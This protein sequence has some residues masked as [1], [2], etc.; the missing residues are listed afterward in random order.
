MESR[1]EKRTK[2]SQKAKRCLAELLTPITKTA[3]RLDKIFAAA[4]TSASTATTAC[5][6]TTTT[7]CGTNLIYNNS[8]NSFESPMP[9]MN[10]A[11]DFARNGDARGTKRCWEE[12]HTPVPRAA[13]AVATAPGAFYG[14]DYE[15]TTRVGALD[16]RIKNFRND[17]DID[18]FDDCFSIGMRMQRMMEGGE[19][20]IG[21]FT[22]IPSEVSAS[23]GGIPMIDSN[24][25]KQLLIEDANRVVLIDCRYFYEYQNGHI[26]QSAHVMFPED[27]QRGFLLARDKLRL[28]CTNN[29][30]NSNSSNNRDSERKENLVYVFYDDG[31]ANAMPMH[32][33]A[34]QLFR[35]IR[36][37]DRLDNMHTYPNLYFPNMYVLKGGF[38]AFIESSRDR[39]WEDGGDNHRRFYEGSFVSTDDWRFS[40]ETK[41]LRNQFAKRWNLARSAQSL[42][43]FP[44]RV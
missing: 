33:R 23:H 1:E 30:N 3:V 10:L 4:S 41:E 2:S 21:T 6:G 36:N 26:V 29:N 37:L 35:H 7:N 22:S 5:G 13:A 11:N 42:S 25:V 18:D 19:R 32:H 15:T 34:M 14:E 9:T 28:N 39:E 12:E 24:T 16:E 44:T 31:E 27:C 40:N 8:F 43:D 17:D 38:K 20:E